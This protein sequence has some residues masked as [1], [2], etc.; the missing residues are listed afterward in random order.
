[1]AYAAF[2]WEAGTLRLRFSAAKDDVGVQVVP[3]VV[4][5]SRL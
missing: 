4:P 1:M 5:S 3:V 2:S